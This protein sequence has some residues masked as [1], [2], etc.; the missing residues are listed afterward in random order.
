[1]EELRADINGLLRGG[2]EPKPN[3]NKA[4]VKAL[5]ELKRDKDGIVLT[6]DK[7]VAM[8]VLDKENYIERQKISWCNQLTGP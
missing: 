4:E 8:V 7:G 1:M 6:V 5:A 3:L 2:Q